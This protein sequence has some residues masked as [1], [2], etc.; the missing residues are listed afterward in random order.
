MLGLQAIS[1]S[2]NARLAAFFWSAALLIVLISL[3]DSQ[4]QRMAVYCTPSILTPPAE[5]AEQG[6]FHPE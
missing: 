3:Q 6:V 1:F 5:L 2:Y 4:Y